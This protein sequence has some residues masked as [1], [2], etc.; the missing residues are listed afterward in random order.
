MN[1]VLRDKEPDVPVTVMVDEAAGVEAAVEIVNVEVHVGRHD[2]GEKEAVAPE[3]KPEAVKETDEAEP[4]T[5]VSVTVL[6]TD[7][8]W[9]TER[10]PALDIEKSKAGAVL[11]TVNV[12]GAD[13][14]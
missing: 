12:T 11:F 13:V 5:R 3:G 9:T 1:E 10:L 2:A 4:E 6:E 7:C 14:A 8:P